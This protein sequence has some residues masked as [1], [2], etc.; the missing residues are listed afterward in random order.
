MVM[1][2]AKNSSSFVQPPGNSYLQSF[3]AFVPQ[4]FNPQKWDL[5][6]WYVNE[7]FPAYAKEGGGLA[8]GII[9]EAVVNWGIY[10]IIFQAFIIAAIIR[11]A[12]F[13]SYRVRFKQVDI[14]VLFYLFCFSNIYSLVRSYSFSLI[15]GLM[16]GFIIP[17][18]G[19][20]IINQL[21]PASSR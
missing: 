7:Y 15:A 10:S 13:S 17:V 6:S 8:F 14:R 20:Y 9:P 5:P 18:L 19:V 21:R 1:I 16:L 12:Y 3:I 4:Q 2:S 11:V